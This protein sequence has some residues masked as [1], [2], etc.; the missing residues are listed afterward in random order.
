MFLKQCL[1][2]SNVEFFKEPPGDVVKKYKTIKRFAYI[3]H[4]KDPG[5]SPHWTIYLDFGSSSQDTKLIASWFGLQ[6][7][8]VEK[9]KGRRTDAL[10]YLT[11][12]NDTQRNKYQYPTSEVTAN[13]DFQNEITAAQILGDFEHYS[14]AEQLLYVASLPPS[15]QPATFNRLE[16]L[17]RIYCRKLSLGTDRKLD[18]IFV[19][20]SAGTGKTYYAKKLMQAMDC[21]FCISSSSND[22]F[23]D[24]M[25]QKGMILDDLRDDAFKF[26]D[27]LKIL[28]NYTSSSVSSRFN[29]KVFNG[30]VLI[31]TSTVPLNL[32]YMDKRYGDYDTLDQLYRR[33]SCYVQVTKKEVKVYN[34][35]V[36][37]LGKPKGLGQIFRN[38]LQDVIA[39]APP[40][41]TDFGELF[42]KICTP[43]SISFDD[44]VQMKTNFTE[45]QNEKK[46]EQ[47]SDSKN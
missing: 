10:Q 44:P 28:D 35:G 39:K 7:S 45:I 18:V 8:Q 14:Y 2:T 46:A 21:D 19:Q 9:I 38:E 17:W 23:Q 27:L 26:E 16:S 3:L 32:W 47:K 5:T 25:G 31:L 42:E 33:I 29:N 4:D 43:E 30:K 34:D 41:R 11:H 12:S 24:Y 15:E 22:P 1:V 40:A 36:D 6:E 20:G 13:F 37:N